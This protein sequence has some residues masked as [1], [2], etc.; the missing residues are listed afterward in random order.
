[1]P[2]PTEQTP[3]E[4]TPPAEAQE[5]QKVTFDDAQ[6]ARINEIV[7]E[8]SARAGA[9]A[10]AELARV[11]ATLPPVEQS[12][13]ALLKLAEAQSELASLKAEATEAKVREILNH[14]VSKE[15]FFDPELASQILRSSIK[16]ID[17]K[18]TVVDSTGTPRLDAEFNPMSPE[19]LAKE[20]ASTKRFLVKGELRAGTGSVMSTQRGETGP[21]LETIFGKHSN[22]AAANRLAM[23]DIGLYRRLREKARSEGII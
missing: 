8:A 10:R 20:L 17:G 11:K 3:L 16:V 6:K 2:E 12:A 23:K 1:M 14:A 19:T 15:S 7:K 21:A 5:P 22:G 9:E 13:D 4:Q 18:P